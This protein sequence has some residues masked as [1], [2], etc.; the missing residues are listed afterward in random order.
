M[1]IETTQ[2]NVSERPSSVIKYGPQLVS[3]LSRMEIDKIPMGISME[4]LREAFPNCK[5][6][7]DSLPALVG[8][9]EDGGNYMFIFYDVDKF[10]KRISVEHLDRLTAI[11]HIDK[12][13]EK[14]VFV[15]PAELKGKPYE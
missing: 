6:V 8:P 15:R 3:K 5:I 12:A 1:E 2:A 14:A 11:V 9:A 7:S 13:N 10:K 4:G